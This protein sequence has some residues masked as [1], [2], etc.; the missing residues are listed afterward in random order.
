MSQG[1]YKDVMSVQEATAVESSCNARKRCY[2]MPR[3]QGQGDGVLEALPQPLETLAFDALRVVELA[4][5]PLGGDERNS[6]P[7]RQCPLECG[8]NGFG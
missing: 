5:S 7:P 6:V 8:D 3:R 1:R 2:S 4:G